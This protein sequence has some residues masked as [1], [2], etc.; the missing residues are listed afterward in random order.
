MSESISSHGRLVVT[1]EASIANVW[2]EYQRLVDKAEF[3]FI[4]R[5]VVN[6]IR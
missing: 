5:A 2:S 1:N 6:I 4:G 3:D